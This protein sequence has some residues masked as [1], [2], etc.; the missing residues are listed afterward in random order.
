MHPRGHIPDHPEVV[1]RRAGLHLHPKFGAIM[2]RA[3]ALP[4]ATTNRAKLGA[5]FGGPGVLDQHDTGSCEGHAHA[6]AATLLLA[7]QGKSPGLISPTA[8]YMG[9]LMVDSTIQ[10]DGTLSPITDTGTM[11]SSIL[12]AWQI[13]GAELA[14]D[15]P[16]YPAQSSTLY[17]TPGDPNSQLIMPAVEKLYADSPFRFNGAYFIN[18]IGAAALLQALSVLAAG[19]TITDAIPASGSDFQ[20]YT[21]GI[22]GA[23]SGPTDHA[24]HILD[25]EWTGS[26][27]DWATFTTGLGQG[28]LDVTLAKQLV[29]HCVNSWG[30][31]WGE[32]DT[33]AQAIGGLYRANTDYFAQAQSLCVV[34]LEAA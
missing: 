3:S 10:A 33:V 24:N 5:S 34:D 1:K 28:T 30:E 6:S 12:S 16:Q 19:F 14:K 15:D 25:H 18:A 22:L 20:Q 32:G 26:A 27:A 29:L 23:L 4:M 2:A 7:N 31:A 8:L 11:P 17:V 21:G 9:A 13:F